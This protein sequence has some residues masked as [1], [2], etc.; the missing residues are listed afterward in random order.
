MQVSPL[1]AGSTHKRILSC[2]THFQNTEKLGGARQTDSR[3]EGTCP[4][5]SGPLPLPQQLFPL[6]SKQSSGHL[7]LQ[8]LAFNQ[9]G[10]VTPKEEFYDK[11]VNTWEVVASP[12]S[13]GFIWASLSGFQILQAERTRELA[14]QSQ[15]LPLYDSESGN[16]TH[17][18]LLRPG[19][20][21][22]WRMGLKIVPREQ[23]I[24]PHCFG[25]RAPGQSSA[26]SIN[27][28]DSQHTTPWQFHH[29]MGPTGLSD[30]CHSQ[31][32][33]QSPHLL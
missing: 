24:A 10:P 15:S 20:S 32:I 8:A 33:N 9:R 25:Q 5:S 16:H 23:G 26:D 17:Q 2:K 29:F 7:W 28:Q 13:G 22:T 31:I 14:S 3:C 27:S 18:A 4:V 11:R 19:E 6:R 30:F 1:A 21:W 12:Y